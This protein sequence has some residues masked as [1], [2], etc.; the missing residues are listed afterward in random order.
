MTAVMQMLRPVRLT[1]RGLEWEGPVR[2]APGGDYLV[3]VDG[4]WG[5]D[6]AWVKLAQQQIVL[7]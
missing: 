2:S 7:A 5:S 1:P 4:G 3:R 6:E